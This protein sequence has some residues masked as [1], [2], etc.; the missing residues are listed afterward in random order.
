MKTRHCKSNVRHWFTKYA[1]PGTR[2]D[3][4]Q[5]CGADRSEVLRAQREAAKMRRLL[6]LASMG[7]SEL[8]PK[9]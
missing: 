5:H 1:E 8:E 9:R 7:N 2:V 3:K 4:C 6:P